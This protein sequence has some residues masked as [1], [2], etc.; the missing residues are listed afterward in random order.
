MFQRGEASRAALSQL[1]IPAST[2]ILLVWLIY[3]ENGSFP[4]YASSDVIPVGAASV[5]KIRSTIVADWPISLGKTVYAFM[6]LYSRLLEQRR[7]GPP[8]NDS[9]S[10]GASATDDF[11]AHA[12]LRYRKVQG[13]L[14]L[15]CAAVQG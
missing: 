13:P 12:K 11:F 7:M 8:P 10:A 15:R 2:E 14:S 1:S 6:R 9:A 3:R 4:F 5:D